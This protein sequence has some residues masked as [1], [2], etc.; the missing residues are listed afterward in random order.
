MK[1]LAKCIRKYVSMIRHSGALKPK[2]DNKSNAHGKVG[3]QTRRDAGGT[4]ISSS[5]CITHQTDQMPMDDL[6]FQSRYI[7]GLH[8][9]HCL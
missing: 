9:L 5:N 1:E 6:C 4:G 2:P 8:D 3:F 7:P